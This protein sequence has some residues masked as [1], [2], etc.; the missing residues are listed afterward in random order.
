MSETY[1]FDSVEYYTNYQETFT[2]NFINF[3]P[4]KM[5]KIMFLDYAFCMRF[6]G[7]NLGIL[8]ELCNHIWDFFYFLTF[9][10][11]LLRMPQWRKKS[12][13]SVFPPPR[14]FIFGQWNSPWRRGLSN[15]YMFYI[16]LNSS[17]IWFKMA[18]FCLV[19]ITLRWLALYRI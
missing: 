2:L 8:I 1:D 5:S 10:N 17:Y 18:L 11:F 14:T 6:F 9:P 13:N 4:Q 3:V 12:I 19:I 15:N 7:G 16:V